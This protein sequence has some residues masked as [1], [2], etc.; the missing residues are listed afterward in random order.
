MARIC[1]IPACT[2]HV[3]PGKPVC[4]RHAQSHEGRELI[5]QV[6]ALAQTLAAHPDLDF[7]VPLTDKPPT[8]ATRQKIERGEYHPLLASPLAQ[9]ADRNAAEQEIDRSLAANRIAIYRLLDDYT[10]PAAMA[11]GI[12]RLTD[13]NTNL[14]KLRYRNRKEMINPT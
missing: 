11:N 7:P 6:R 4:P 12:A 5:R 9:L 2:R 10:E 3:K 1:A 13:S 14:L 8:R